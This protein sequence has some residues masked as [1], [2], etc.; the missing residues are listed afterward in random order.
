M[1]PALRAAESDLNK[2][3]DNGNAP[4]KKAKGK[5]NDDGD[6]AKP[7]EDRKNDNQLHDA[8]NVL[9]AMRLSKES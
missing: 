1:Q 7:D 5:K 3:L 2:H 4:D 9:K 6:N 8:L